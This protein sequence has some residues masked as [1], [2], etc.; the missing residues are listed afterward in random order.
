MYLI[1]LDELV[2]KAE[3]LADELDQEIEAR[4]SAETVIN[5]RTDV[6]DIRLK[7]KDNEADE[8]I[9]IIRGI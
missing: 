1:Q 4:E 3:E 8:K 2:E 9:K 6:E 7:L 5:Q